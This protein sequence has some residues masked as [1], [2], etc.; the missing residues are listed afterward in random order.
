MCCVPLNRVLDQSLT[1]PF[2]P[3][4]SVYTLIVE[5]YWG[6]NH[7]ICLEVI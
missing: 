1:L 4:L 2:V 7:N 3:L 5:T 6:L